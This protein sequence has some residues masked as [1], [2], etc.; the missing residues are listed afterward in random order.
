M[1]FLN[2]NH[3]EAMLQQEK[4]EPGLIPWEA[5]QNRTIHHGSISEKS[6]LIDSSKAFA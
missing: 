2:E 1:L 5:A 6:F 3:K 4:E